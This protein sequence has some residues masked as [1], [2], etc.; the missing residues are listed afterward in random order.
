MGKLI[1]KYT[2]RSPSRPCLKVLWQG[3]DP[4][5]FFTLSLMLPDT[6]RCCPM[7]GRSTPCRTRT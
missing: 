1:F 2:K 5:T 7:A 3:L 4:N 6:S